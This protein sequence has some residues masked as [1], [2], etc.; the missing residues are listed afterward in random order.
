MSDSL[1]TRFGVTWHKKDSL[2]ILPYP[3]HLFLQIVI[4]QLQGFYLAAH[5][6]LLNL[7]R[8]PL[9]ARARAWLS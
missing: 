3:V 8:V 5:P 2:L 6:R 9:G 7:Y 1:P 4:V